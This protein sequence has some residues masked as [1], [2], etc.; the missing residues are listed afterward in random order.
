[1][2]ADQKIVWVEEGQKFA[3][4]ILTSAG[5]A[6]V[7]GHRKA[8]LEGIGKAVITS[9]E[10]TVT[11]KVLDSRSTAGLGQRDLAQVESTL[12]TTPW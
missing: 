10:K 5:A 1:M 7:N 2:S 11:Q 8:V 12:K 4:G 6:E 9:R 3:G